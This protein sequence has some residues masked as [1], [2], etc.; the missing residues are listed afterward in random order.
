MTRGKKTCRILKEIRKQIAEKNDI[1]YVTSECTFQ[2]EC[3]GT[4]PKC[5]SELR[6]LENELN[7]RRQ[8]GKVVA[9]AGISLGLA[10]TFSACNS[11]SQKQSNTHISGKEEVLEGIIMLD[12]SMFSSPFPPPPPPPNTVWAIDDQNVISLES[13]EIDPFLY[14]DDIP[15]K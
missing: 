11:P 13:G 3:E 10:S 1:E 5:E 4:C 14:D 9:I 8:L 15:K 12:H 6:Y 2:W 7:K